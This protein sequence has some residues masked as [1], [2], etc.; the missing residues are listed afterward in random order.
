[1]TTKTITA[2]CYCK[3]IHYTLTLPVSALPISTHLC[4]CSRCRYTHGTLCIFHAEIPGDVHPRFIAPSSLEKFTTLY[5]SSEDNSGLHFCST[6]GCHMGDYSEREDKWVVAT[7]LFSKDESVFIF[8][9][10]IFTKSS[11]AGLQDW[12]PKIGDREM[13]VWN[14]DD[15]SAEPT[16]PEAEVGANGEERLRAQCHCG[17]VSFT[18]PRPTKEVLDDDWMS[19]FVSPVDKAKWKC[20]I[21]ACNDCRL[22][23]GVEINAWLFAPLMLLEPKIDLDF[24]HGT[25][26]LYVSSPGTTRTF[27]DVCRATVFFWCEERQTKPGNNIVDISAGLLRAPEGVRADNWTTWRTYEIGWLEAGYKYDKELYES[28]NEGVQKWGAETQGQLV[29]FK[30]D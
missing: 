19:K 14:P 28:L 18:L 17:G 20:C 8:N 27:C 2:Q 24:K 1:M 21:D 12:L 30:I 26:K 9:E 15:G 10:H 5:P 22:I 4:H 7:A 3:S 11:P 13:K 16:I 6:C 25:L 23:S 29:D